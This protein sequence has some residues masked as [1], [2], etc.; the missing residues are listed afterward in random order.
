MKLDFKMLNKEI[1]FQN[2]NYNNNTYPD[3][4]LIYVLHLRKPTTDKYYLLFF[5]Q[6]KIYDVLNLIITEEIA[7][8]TIT[9]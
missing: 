6:Q 7:F 5:I 8:L 1:I 9:F 3:K 4:V 2:N